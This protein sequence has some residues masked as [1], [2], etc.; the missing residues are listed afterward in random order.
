MIKTSHE[1]MP[2]IGLLNKGLNYV[3]LPSTPPINDIIETSALK[4]VPY[5][6]RTSIRS[7]SIKFLQHEL[8][9]IQKPENMLRPITSNATTRRFSKWLTNKLKDLLDPPELFVKNTQE[10]DEKVND[11][12]LA[13][14]EV[15]VSFDVERFYPSVP[16]AEAL[17]NFPCG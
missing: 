4:M 13:Q 2:D 12:Q 11:V 15:L 8:P 7:R 10:F 5:E 3:H 14:D 17:K 16:I 1:E 9:K 6:E